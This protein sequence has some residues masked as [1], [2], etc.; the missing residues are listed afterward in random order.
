MALDGSLGQ[1]ER[2]G[3]LSIRLALGHERG[4]PLLG[5]CEL[6]GA[7][8]AAADPL[9]LSAGTLCPQL[10]ADALEHCKRLLERRTRLAPALQAPLSH[11]EREQRAAPVERDLDDCMEPQRFLE[12]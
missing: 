4:H 1:E 3:H 10:R 9:E 5:R 11:P 8:R 7:R 6:A 12:A 2:R